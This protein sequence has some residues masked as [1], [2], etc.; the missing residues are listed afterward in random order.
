MGF[1]PRAISLHHIYAGTMLKVC[2]EKQPDA[3]IYH[4]C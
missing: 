3:L 2:A 1:I 4:C